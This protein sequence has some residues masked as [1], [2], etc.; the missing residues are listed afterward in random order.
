MELVDEQDHI[1]ILRHLV[2]DGF[3]PLLEISSI[4]RSC[5]DRTHVQRDESLVGKHRWD[6]SRNYLDGN[7]F[8]YGGF[9]DSRVADQHR[10]VLSA[11]SQNLDHALDFC[12]SSN[13]RI[14]LSFA[15]SLGYVVSELLERG[16]AL[17]FLTIFAHRS[18]P[19]LRNFFFS[20]FFRLIFSSVKHFVPVEVAEYVSVFDAGVLQIGASIRSSSLAEGKEQVL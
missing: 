4:L 10:I 13:E 9:A 17:Y 8:H 11:A 20:F 19:Y 15:C 16:D 3:Q 6:I 5:H 12:F 14:E 1:R 2:D 18:D 7:A